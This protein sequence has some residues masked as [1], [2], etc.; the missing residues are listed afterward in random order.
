[1]SLKAVIYLCFEAFLYL[2][3]NRKER[4]VQNMKTSINLIT[5]SDVEATPVNWLWFPYIPYG[6]ITLIQGD[7]GDGKTTFVLAISA[8]LTN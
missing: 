1:M 6:K 8:L 4:T 2:P 3:T 5:M 7:P